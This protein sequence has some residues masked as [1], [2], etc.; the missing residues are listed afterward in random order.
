MPHLGKV[1]TTTQLFV[2]ITNNLFVY[3]H[4]G[5]EQFFSP[6]DKE[7]SLQRYQKRREQQDVSL[8]S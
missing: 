2:T 8:F 7:E 3:V 5:G 4:P 1:T 6:A